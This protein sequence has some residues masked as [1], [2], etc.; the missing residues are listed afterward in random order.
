[1]WSPEDRAKLL[2]SLATEVH[3]WVARP[4]G[5]E[6]EHLERFHGWL[7]PAEMARLDRRIFAEDRHL[8]LIAHALK[9]FTVSR[10]LPV[11]PHR[12]TFDIGS[13]GKP[14]IAGAEAASGLR[15]NLSHVDGM[16]ACLV[17]QDID[18]GVDVENIDRELDH[19]RVAREVFSTGEQADLLALDGPEMRRRFFT[20]WTLKE[21]YLKAC[22][23]GLGAAL[24]QIEF[25][26]REGEQIELSFLPPF[27][28]DPQDWQLESWPHGPAHRLSVALRV[29]DG[30]RKNVV[31]RKASLL[32]YL[33]C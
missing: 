8:F 15:F 14:E 29:G 28:D 22:G 7:S 32:E 21:A 31:T 19:R 12:W 10:Y 2:S 5:Y 26:V 6:G 16:V 30:P 25:A 13:S 33:D 24:R 17:A 3:V 23:L 9:R 18:C 1:M 4:G 11:A 20:Y 27:V